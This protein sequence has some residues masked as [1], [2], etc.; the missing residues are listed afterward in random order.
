V[1]GPQLELSKFDLVLSIGPG[2]KVLDL[3]LDLVLEFVLRSQLGLS[4]FAPGAGLGLTR[5]DLVP[6]TGLELTL[7]D[8]EWGQALCECAV[9]G[10]RVGRILVNPR[11][12]A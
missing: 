2:L 1:F 5:L 6:G 10:V 8:C 9:Y 4:D 7:F 3:V 12:N 11:W